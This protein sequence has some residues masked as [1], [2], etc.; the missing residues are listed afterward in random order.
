MASPNAA[1]W[2]KIT[3]LLLGPV[4]EGF[5]FLPKHKANAYEDQPIEA[6]G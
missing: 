1:D 2:V 4:P 3:E 6:E 5:T